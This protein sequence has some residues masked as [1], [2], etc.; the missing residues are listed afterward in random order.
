MKEGDQNDTWHTGQKHS[1]SQ[2]LFDATC[3]NPWRISAG[4]S[5]ESIDSFITRHPSAKFILIDPVSEE[6]YA[7]ILHNVAVKSM[8]FCRQ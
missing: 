7:T 8:G 6:L 5:T 3:R 1:G 4:N 2:S